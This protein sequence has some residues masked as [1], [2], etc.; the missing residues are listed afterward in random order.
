MLQQIM[1]LLQIMLQQIIAAQRQRPTK[2]C[3]I[4]TARFRESVLQWVM[5]ARLRQSLATK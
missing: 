5:A 3:I 1:L 4:Y 2:K